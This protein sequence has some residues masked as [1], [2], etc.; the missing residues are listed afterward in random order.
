M[1]S[2]AIAILNWNGKKLLERFL[3]NVEENSPGAKVYLIDNA[4]TDYSV[5][6]VQRNH[7]TV[8][9]IY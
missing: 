9:I 4:S 5:G 7:P 3:K 2:I 1:S 6:Y 8:K